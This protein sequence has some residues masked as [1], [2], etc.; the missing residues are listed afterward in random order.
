MFSTTSIENWIIPLVFAGHVDT[1]VW[2][3]PFWTAQSM[4]PSSRFY[5]GAAIASNKIRYVQLYMC[6]YVCT[7]GF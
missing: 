4:K 5:V 7:F 2:V 3:K 6:I 1:V